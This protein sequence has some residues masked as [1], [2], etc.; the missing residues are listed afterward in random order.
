[1]PTSFCTR[2]FRSYLFYSSFQS[3]LASMFCRDLSKNIYIYALSFP[4]NVAL[5][6]SWLFL[7][8]FVFIILLWVVRLS[9]ANSV[10]LAKPVSSWYTRTHI[11]TETYTYTHT[12]CTTTII[13]QYIQRKFALNKNTCL[14]NKIYLI[15]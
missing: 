5:F 14:L 6:F 10:A 15:Q 11:H 12:L 8:N 7:F 1:M 3:F 9:S 2:F 13:A 4:L